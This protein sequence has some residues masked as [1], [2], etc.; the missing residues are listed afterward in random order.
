MPVLSKQSVSNAQKDLIQDLL[1]SGYSVCQ[2]AKKLDVHHNNIRRTI[3]KYALEVYVAFDENDSSLTEIDHLT[4][5]AYEEFWDGII[6]DV[7]LHGEA[8]LILDDVRLEERKY[9]NSTYGGLSGYLLAKG[10]GTFRKYIKIKC[11]VCQ[12]MRNVSQFTTRTSSMLGLNNACVY[13]ESKRQRDKKQQIADANGKELG[14]VRRWTTS[15]FAA[16]VSA[17]SG[18]TLKVLGRYRKSNIKT[19]F[20]HVIC[21]ESFYTTPNSV[22]NGTRCPICRSSKGEGKIRMKLQELGLDFTEQYRFKACRNKYPLPF[23]FCVETPIGKVLIEYDGAQHFIAVNAWGGDEGLATIKRRDRI[24]TDFCRAN[25][26]PLI[27]IKYTEFDGI[28]TVLTN[29]LIALGVIEDQSV[30]WSLFAA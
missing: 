11:T 4:D 26:I 24:K 13:C 22:L 25:D 10:Y 12:L 20:L 2:I 7:F 8:E 28:E 29:E 21:G 27:R 14:T 23:D 15:S 30:V 6:S 9:L 19:E 3:S 5:F 1:D 18:G 16:E 17:R